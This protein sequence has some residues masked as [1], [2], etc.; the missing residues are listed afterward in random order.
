MSDAYRTS[1]GTCPT[2]GNT[3]LRE[4]SDRL[5]CD[6]CNGMLLAADD[7]AKSIHELDGRSGGVTF[8]EEGPSD[9]PCPRC[10]GEMMVAEVDISGIRLHGTLVHCARDGVWVPQ[11]VLAG[12]FALASRRGHSGSAHGTRAY[13][14]ISGGASLPGVSGGAAGA[15][16]SIAAGFGRG[17]ATSGLAISQWADTRPRVHTLFV[18]AYKDRTLGC[19]ACKDTK[20]HF[21]GDRWACA[22]CGGCFVEDAALSAMV[23]EMTGKPWQPPA[24]RGGPGERAC[25]VCDKPMLVEVLE[26]V[27]TDRCEGHGVYFDPDELQAALAHAAEPQ[28]VGSFLQ[29]LFHRHHEE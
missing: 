17:S 6:E 19:P 13:G 27:T 2:C 5:V 1:G 9:K 14:G 12:M 15:M 18:S 11:G 23:I 4:F 25:P 22:A 21:A 24:V 26:A 20:L 10:A 16:N 7:L 28:H 8:S 3:A 29:R